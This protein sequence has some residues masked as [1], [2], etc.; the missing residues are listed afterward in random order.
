LLWVW[1]W[2]VWGFCRT[3]PEFYQHIQFPPQDN[4]N[5]LLIVIGL[6]SLFAALVSIEVSSLLQHKW[7][8]IGTLIFA[9]LGFVCFAYLL[10]LRG[11]EYRTFLPF[12]ASL[13]QAIGVT[14]AGVQNA[15]NKNPSQIERGLN[16]ASRAV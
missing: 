6:F 10:G 16:E 3:I 13:V 5:T 12:V 8:I 11:F 14:I 9:M 1:P 15:W 4:A 2:L 7:L